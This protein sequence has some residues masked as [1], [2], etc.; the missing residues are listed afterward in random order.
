MAKLKQQIPW[1]SAA[2]IITVVSFGL[3]FGTGGTVAA[4]AV[5]VA[6]AGG[7]NQ[8][9]RS[10]LV[11]ESGQVMQGDVTV[12][13]GDV[14][15]DNGGQIQ[16]SLVVYRGDIQIEA[17][18]SVGRDVTSFSGD[19][20]I[21]G[22]V[23]G[24]VASWSGDVDLAAT[25]RVEGGISVLSGEI[26][27]D[28]GAYVG[29]N[30][31]QGPHL[32]L[33]RMPNPEFPAPPNTVVDRSF[34]FFGWIGQLFL[35]LIS[36][37]LLTALAALLVGVLVSAR[38]ELV[39]RVRGK[40]NENL[41][42]SFVVGLLANLALLFL[43][44]LLSVTL[45]LLPI[46][47]IPILLLLGVNLVG[48]SAVSQVV[49]ERITAYVKQPV[50]PALT[51]AVGAVALTGVVTLLWA[52]GGC[53]RFAGF[54]A[55]LGVASF[56]TGAVLLP[57]LN[58][59]RPAGEPPVRTAPTGE[60]PAGPRRG[61]APAAPITPAAETVQPAA[62]ASSDEAILKD[63]LAE[64]L[65]YVTAQD[66]LAA[67]AEEIQDDDFARIKGIGLVFEQRLKNAGIRTFGELA[68]TT[69]ERIA[70]IIGWPVE[71]VLR[72]DING[73]ARYFSEN[74]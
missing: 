41:A 47:L 7:A 69:P 9:F 49:G 59:E 48:W 58:R 70:E 72:S 50:Q 52:M 4:Q 12:Y 17:G 61:P 24:D 63:D 11:V 34:G 42:L 39:S 71:R 67:Q 22:Q 55:V 18:A 68:I 26:H 15:I 16:G 54:L 5:R 36:A 31:A 64:P 3:V 45:C 6:Q 27:R 65:D 8:I 62:A 21:D 33:P 25:A 32:R 13:D 38:P 23:G 10:D 29:G 66:V 40:M 35:R 2:L 44:G 57:W 14:R 43:A 73:Q 46:A 19:V 53:F 1:L 56:G 74:R 30:V 37:A 20:M 28:Q 60:P 51:A